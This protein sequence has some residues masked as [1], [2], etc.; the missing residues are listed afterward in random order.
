MQQDNQ[1]DTAQ[2]VSCGR[3]SGGGA[4]M[5]R[6]SITSDVKG[7]GLGLYGGRSGGW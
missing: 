6:R 2:A 4:R 5:C 7:R 1:A 3:D